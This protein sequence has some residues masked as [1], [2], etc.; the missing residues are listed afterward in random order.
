[1]GLQSTTRPSGF[2]GLKVKTS[3]NEKSEQLHSFC[4]SGPLDLKSYELLSGWI[5]GSGNVRSRK[6]IDA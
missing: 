3:E 1:M 4:W 5:F 2:S 6:I